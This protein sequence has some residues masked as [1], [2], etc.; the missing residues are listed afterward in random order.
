MFSCLLFKRVK[1]KLGNTK[2]YI[3]LTCNVWS[4]KIFYG[5]AIV[6]ILVIKSVQHTDLKHF[7]G[8]HSVLSSESE[9]TNL[10]YLEPLTLLAML[11]MVQHLA[12]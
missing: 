3:L 4:Q 6:D 7:L 10:K 8:D 9:V 11:G 1:S 12:Q 5:E 2:N